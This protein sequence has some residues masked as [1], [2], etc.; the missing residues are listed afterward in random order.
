MQRIVAALL[1]LYCFLPAVLPAQRAAA[2]G[3]RY[4]RLI[5]LVHLTGSGKNGD[6]V[7]PEYVTEGTAIARAA[8]T[9][10]VAAATPPAGLNSRAL[11]AAPV[12]TAPVA[13]VP[14]TVGVSAP[15]AQRPG[16]LAW[17][18]QV[19]DDGKMAIIHIVAADRHAFDSILADKR[20]EIRVFEIGKDSKDKIEAEL[21]KFKKN[22][23]LDSFPLEVQ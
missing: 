10:A 7:V 4:F 21:R 12:A 16:Y 2:P 13:R 11:A 20:P 15:M 5:C 14:A 23:E 17:R 9:I 22:F 18:M 8:D 19:T 1:F 3:N 6:P